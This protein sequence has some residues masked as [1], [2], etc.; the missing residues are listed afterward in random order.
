MPA[1]EPESPFPEK[2]VLP[3]SSAKS[4]STITILFRISILPFDEIFN[5]SSPGVLTTDN[6]FLVAYNP[7]VLVSK[8]NER[9]VPKISFGI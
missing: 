2:N 8:A 4:L 7:N 6:L 5:L 3:K 1:N 9:C